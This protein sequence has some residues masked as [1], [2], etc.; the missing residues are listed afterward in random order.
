MTKK[1][2]SDQLDLACDLIQSHAVEN[3]NW[4]TNYLRPLHKERILYDCILVD[5]LTKNQDAKILDMGSAPFYAALTLKKMGYDMKSTDIDP[6]RF[7]ALTE[8]INLNI[9]RCDFEKEKLPF[10]DD[11]FD[12]IL[13]SEVFEHLRIDLIFT[14]S[15]IRRVL[16]PGGKFILSSPNF[17]EYFKLKRLL[18]KGKTSEIFNAYK[19][20]H[21]LGHMGHV[22][23]YTRNDVILFL[24]KMKFT[25][26]DSHYR[27]IDPKKQNDSWQL[28]N[29]W[30]QRFFPFFRKWFVV[31]ASK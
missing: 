26:H 14:I 18:F 27:G 20:L 23:E 3:Q 30:A 12:I 16:K 28:L 17:F 7:G 6:E 19:K 15:E 24:E 11:S 10:E 2:I 8:K 13:L 9:V 31:I 1:D 4:I 22:R 25:I 29:H 21:D 5:S